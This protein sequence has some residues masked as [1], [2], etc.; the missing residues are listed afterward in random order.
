MTPRHITHDALYQPMHKV[1]A[2]KC[3][4]AALQQKTQ[5]FAAVTRHGRMP[6]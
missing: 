2:A 5:W 3:L 1:S 6:H 4:S